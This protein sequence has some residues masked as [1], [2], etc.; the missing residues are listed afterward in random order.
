MFDDFDIMIQSDELGCEY[1]D[2]CLEVYLRYCAIDCWEDYD[3][4]EDI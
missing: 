2:Y 1:E 4:Q 3:G